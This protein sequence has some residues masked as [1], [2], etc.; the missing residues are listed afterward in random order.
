MMDDMSITQDHLRQ[1]L[2]FISF[3]RG[4]RPALAA[5]NN[6]AR[7][8]RSGEGAETARGGEAANNDSS[9][10]GA[11][12]LSSTNTPAAAETPD[13]DRKQGVRR[14]AGEAAGF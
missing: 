5:V 8:E 4:A 1:V 9:G 6:E 7:A 11:A 12:L 13:A 14:D 3:M 2:K 10:N